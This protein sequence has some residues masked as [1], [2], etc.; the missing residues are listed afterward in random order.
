[1]RTELTLKEKV[2]LLKGVTARNLRRLDTIIGKLNPKTQPQL[3]QSLTGITDD[4]AHTL[5][6]PTEEQIDR[7]ID[8]L[9]LINDTED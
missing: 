8:N 5:N 1:M 3:I 4:L 6:D 7:M 9:R 2:I